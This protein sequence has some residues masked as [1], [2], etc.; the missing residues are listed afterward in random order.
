MN[1]RD[2]QRE[3]IPLLWSRA[4]ERALAKF[5]SFKMGVTRYPFVCRRT[6]RTGRDAQRDKVIEKGKR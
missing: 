1:V 6:K 5:L 4:R 2:V 3:R